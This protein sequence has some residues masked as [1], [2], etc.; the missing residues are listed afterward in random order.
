MEAE[1]S[2]HDLERHYTKDT[3]D[4]HVNGNLTVVWRNWD[5]II[6]N[7]EM[8][9]VNTV[10]PHEI[11]G[12]HLHKNRTSY[13]YCMQGEIIMVIR[14]K[15]NKIH[16][17]RT[18]REYPVLIEIPNGTPSA[19][20]NPSKD[21]TAEVLVLADIAWKPNDNE[22]VNIEFENYEWERLTHGN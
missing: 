2:I 13:F 4:A 5:E 14:D 7:P 9:Y 8:V 6:K 20:V 22:M 17:I 16:E 21:V 12:P 1:F 15:K 19:I 18:S 11:K 3:K 10:N